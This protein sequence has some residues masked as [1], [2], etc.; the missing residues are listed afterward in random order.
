MTHE[1]RN[2]SSCLIQDW[3]FLQLCIVMRE[4]GWLCLLVW[5]GFNDCCYELYR[6]LQCWKEPSEINE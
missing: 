1:R 4:G 3:T 5:A 2:L 6:G